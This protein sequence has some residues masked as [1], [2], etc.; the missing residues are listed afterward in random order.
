MLNSIVLVGRLKEIKENIIIIAVPRNYKNEDG[1]Y[2]TDFIEC[3]ISKNINEKIENWCKVG[4][5]LGVRGRV[6]TNNIIKAD[7]I[8]F[9]STNT[10]G[11][12]KE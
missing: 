2:E 5:V 12:D 6:E 8:S 7:K 11:E 3:Q 9:L 1:E 4:D 10:K